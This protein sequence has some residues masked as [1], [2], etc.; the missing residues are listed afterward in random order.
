[1]ANLIK[2]GHTFLNIDRV[3]C[4]EDLYLSTKEDKVVI[5]FSGADGGSYA[6]TGRD[7]DDLRTWLNAT[8]VNLR[9]DPRV[10]S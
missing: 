10:D 2:I 5:R 4:I 7:A 9:L 1:M 8:A 6:Y 3:E